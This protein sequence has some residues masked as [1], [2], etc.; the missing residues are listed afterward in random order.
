MP[1]HLKAETANMFFVFQFLL[2]MS[3][4]E[5][6]GCPR[7]PAARYPINPIRL[8]PCGGMVM[9]VCPMRASGT[10][11]VVAEYGG[12][13]PTPCLVLRPAPIPALAAWG[14]HSAADPHRGAGDECHEA[15]SQPAAKGGVCHQVYNYRII[16]LQIAKIVFA[17]NC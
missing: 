16:F 14:R 17:I 4:C 10:L 8:L 3:G 15:Q 6:C 2:F 9:R 1:P 11:L 7:V 5:L 13:S 12:V